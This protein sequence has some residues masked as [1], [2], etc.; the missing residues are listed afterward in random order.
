MECEGMSYEE[1]GNEA[2]R[3]EGMK[4]EGM[5]GEGVRSEVLKDVGTEGEGGACLE[6]Q[7]LESVEEWRWECVPVVTAPSED[8]CTRAPREEVSGREREEV[9]E[10]A[11]EG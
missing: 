8:H 7:S 6:V 9:R 2:V 5:R 10:K 3:G 1:M 4:G 11:E